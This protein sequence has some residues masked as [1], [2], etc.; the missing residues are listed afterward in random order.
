[1]TSQNDAGGA[2][3]G[4]CSKDE[5]TLFTAR[6]MSFMEQI[7]SWSTEGTYILACVHQFGQFA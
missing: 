3:V 7:S 5:I 1:M 2:F 4:R 6:A